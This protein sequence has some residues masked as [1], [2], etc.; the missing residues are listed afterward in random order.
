MDR[1]PSYMTPMKSGQKLHRAVDLCSII[2]GSEKGQNNEKGNKH[3]KIYHCFF[4][5]KTVV[6]YFSDS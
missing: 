1:L 4:L 5:N 2:Y 3:W 6:A